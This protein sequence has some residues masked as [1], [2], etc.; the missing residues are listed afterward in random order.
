MCTIGIVYRVH[1]DWP[2]L[3]AA[4]RDEFYARGATPPV[5]LRENGPRIVGGRDLV[6]SGAADSGEED[7]ED[8]EDSEEQETP[9]AQRPRGM[10]MEEVLTMVLPP[11]EMVTTFD[12]EAH[13]HTGGVVGSPGAAPTA[14]AVMVIALPLARIFSPWTSSRVLTGC[15]V[16][17]S[18]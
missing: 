4:N 18:A 15:E 1:A 16:V 17:I 6:S 12:P 9:P 7:A 10:R 3:V 11:S 14:E 2:L 8:G 13:G 5:V